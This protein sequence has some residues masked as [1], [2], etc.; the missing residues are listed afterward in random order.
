MMGEL[1]FGLV[2]FEVGRHLI[3]GLKTPRV[4]R[5][6]KALD[7]FPVRPMGVKEA[8]RRAVAST[9]EAVAAS[10]SNGIRHL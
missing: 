3:E 5:D 8:I 7:V 9:T 2:P 6:K 4:V 1:A 10:C